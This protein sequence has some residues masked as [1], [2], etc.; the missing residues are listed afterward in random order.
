MQAR[1]PTALALEARFGLD[2]LPFARRAATR[3]AV[4]VGRVLGRPGVV[5]VAVPPAPLGVGLAIHSMSRALLRA[6]RE[7]RALEEDVPLGAL[8]DAYEA[9]L[10]NWLPAPLPT[11]LRRLPLN[12]SVATVLQLLDGEARDEHVEAAAPADAS[13][14][15]DWLFEIAR[16]AESA[17][18]SVSEA[19]ETVPWRAFPD[20]AKRTDVLRALGVRDAALAAASGF[21]GGEAAEV[22]QEAV[23]RA[24]AEAG[25]NQ[26]RTS[27]P[28]EVHRSLVRL[29]QFFGV[30]G[31]S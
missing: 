6:L 13:P 14:N 10:V 7:G 15:P 12:E 22:V 24:M 18:L 4:A 27:T 16:F 19:L 11:V 21:G 23:A 26:H 5:T 30:T 9:V 28:A 17:G 31:E 1:I 20:E 2:R 8:Y 3:V 25:L 29:G